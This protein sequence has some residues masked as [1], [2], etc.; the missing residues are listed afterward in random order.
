[1]SVMI[2]FLNLKSVFVGLSID[3]PNMH[4]MNFI[5]ISTSYN[6]LGVCQEAF[7]VVRILSYR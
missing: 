6:L 3:D 2:Q 7:Q 4:I 5:R 1:M